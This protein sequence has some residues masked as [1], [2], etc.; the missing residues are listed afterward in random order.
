M[1]IY[2]PEYIRKGIEPGNSI[3]GE[4]FKTE[5]FGLGAIKQRNFFTMHYGFAIITE[6]LLDA[7][8][9]IFEDSE[10]LEVMSGT[11]Y[12]AKL[13]QD[14]FVNV[15]ATDNKSWANGTMYK[16][17]KNEKCAI[18]NYSATDAIDTFHD[19]VKYVIMSWPPYNEPTAF[20]VAKKC[21][22]YN[23]DLLYIGEDWDG[24]T[25]DDNFFDLIYDYE[26]ESIEDTYGFTHLRFMGIHDSPLLIHFSKGKNNKEKPE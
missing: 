9:K 1:Q 24:C 3:Q 17:W 22:E 12:F 23:L 21:I 8:K 15:I 10:V 19:R 11:G 14:K 18:L 6:E 7:C 20:E 26:C 4:Y 16:P 5:D 2:I 13:L 25:A